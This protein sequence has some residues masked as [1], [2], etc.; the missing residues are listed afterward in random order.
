LIERNGTIVYIW[1]DGGYKKVGALLIEEEGGNI[2]RSRF[3]YDE[4]YLKRQ[5]AFPM[6]PAGLPLS[7]GDRIMTNRPGRNMFGFIDSC[8]DNWGQWILGALATERGR[9][10]SNFEWLM[11]GGPNRIGALAYGDKRGPLFKSDLQLE[12]QTHTEYD[13]KLMQ[14]AMTEFEEK[15]YH[16]MNRI[17]RRYLGGGSSAGGARPKTILTLEDGT[18]ALAKFRSKDDKMNVCRVEYATM[19]F[20]REIGLPVPPT[21]IRTIEG[22]DIFLIERFDRTPA[23]DKFHL[24]TASTMVQ[25]NYG[26]RYINDRHYYSEI[27]KAIDKYGAPGHVQEDRESLFRRMVYNVLMNNEDDHLRNHAFL[28]KEEGWRLSP[29]YDIVPAEQPVR[30]LFT[31]PSDAGTEMTLSNALE[32]RGAFGLSLEDARDIVGEM[33]E[34]FFSDWEKHFLDCGVGQREMDLMERVLGPRTRSRRDLEHDPWVRTNFL[35]QSI[36]VT[37]TVSRSILDD[38]ERKRRDR[39]FDDAVASCAIE[40][41]HLSEE[42]QEEFREVYRSLATSDEMIVHLKNSMGIK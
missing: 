39:V 17:L 35:S 33:T 19:E 4:A 32:G 37:D 15:G 16:G 7:I 27:T 11:A 28:H 3:Q 30:H 12:Y 38:G 9:D 10:F 31:A 42:D 34:R 24:C 40:G 20:A 21:H 36:Q 14:Q 2:Q 8:P 25:A 26:I 29:L 18:P 23:G 41:L 13:L 6:D 5:D 1:L 22:H